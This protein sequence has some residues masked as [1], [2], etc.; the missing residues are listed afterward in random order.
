MGNK[1]FYLHVISRLDSQAYTDKDPRGNFEN[2]APHPLGR[3]EDAQIA[4]CPVA[5]PASIRRMLCV[6]PDGSCPQGRFSFFR[7][8]ISGS[9]AASP[10]SGAKMPSLAGSR[11]QIFSELIADDD[12][13]GPTDILACLPGQTKVWGTIIDR[14]PQYQHGRQRGIYNTIQARKSRFQTWSAVRTLLSTP[15]RTERG[16][17]NLTFGIS[18]EASRPILT[19]MLTPTVSERK[20]R[21]M[22]YC[23][24]FLSSC[25]LAFVAVLNST[26]SVTSSEAT[27]EDLLQTRPISS[28][29]LAKGWE[30]KSGV[31][32]LTGQEYRR[33]S[34]SN[35]VKADSFASVPVSLLKSDWKLSSRIHLFRNPG[36][37]RLGLWDSTGL[38]FLADWIWDVPD[39]QARFDMGY[40]DGREWHSVYGASRALQMNGARSAW[41]DLAFDSA[42]Q[43]A[44]MTFVPAKGQSH[45]GLSV[46]MPSSVMSKIDRV[47]FSCN[48]SEF[49]VLE[50][51]VTRDF[52]AGDPPIPILHHQQ[53]KGGELLI[54][55]GAEPSCLYWLESSYDLKS[56]NNDGTFVGNSPGTFIVHP[57]SSSQFF[58][59]QTR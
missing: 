6:A 5:L 15:C 30:F 33:L 49:T 43:R 31:Y 44:T 9:A 23:V 46:A 32:P 55:W 28:W 29:T 22:V 34:A 53:L 38:R 21:P 17:A 47:G 58:R 3:V 8:T 13:I 1:R 59:V 2:R 20:I 56:W 11:S 51:L 48:Q 39:D 27:T 10:C 41:V 18:A 12:S 7:L 16:K 24:S 4:V 50:F 14:R 54:F 42:T 35:S 52:V 40:W 36:Q 57:D 19:L 26:V 37:T 45:T 25:L